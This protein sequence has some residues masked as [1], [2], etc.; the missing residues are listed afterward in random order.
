MASLDKLIDLQ[1][2]ES[3][4]EIRKLEAH[5]SLQLINR[6]FQGYDPA[7]SALIRLK[8]FILLSTK[9]FFLKLHFFFMFSMHI[10]FCSA[11]ITSQKFDLS[12]IYIILK[13]IERG[14]FL[15]K[16]ISSIGSKYDEKI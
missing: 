1:L 7:Y 8:S 6:E 12:F 5:P 16:K 15:A 14:I 9:Y 10:T 11:E 4:S 3:Q 13:R 2:D